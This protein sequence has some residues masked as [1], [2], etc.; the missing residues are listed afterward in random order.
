[1]TALFPTISISSGG[2]GRGGGPKMV[3]IEDP[4]IDP[5]AY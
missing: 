4:K 3:R 2:S 1:M 5:K